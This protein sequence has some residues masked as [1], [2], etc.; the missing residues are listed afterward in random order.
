MKDSIKVHHDQL[1]TLGAPTNLKEVDLLEVHDTSKISIMLCWPFTERFQNR[2]NYSC[3]LRPFFFLLY[4][5]LN[6]DQ[7]HNSFYVVLP[8]SCNM[9]LTFFFLI[10]GKNILEFKLLSHTKHE[11]IKYGKSVA[12]PTSEQKQMTVETK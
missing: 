10:F 2:T 9:H 7:N 4:F 12:S 11:R 1:Y 8:K 5:C 6:K 3:L